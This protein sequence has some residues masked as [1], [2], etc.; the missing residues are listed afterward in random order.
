M[1]SEYEPRQ[2]GVLGAEKGRIA[3]LV[4]RE[5]GGESSDAKP[6]TPG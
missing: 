3:F 6:G 1:G 4:E 2:D 5:G